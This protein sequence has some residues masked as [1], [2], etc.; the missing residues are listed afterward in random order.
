MKFDLGRLIRR[1]WRRRR[2]TAEEAVKIRPDTPIADPRDDRLGFVVFAEA[3]ADIVDSERTSTP[4]TIALSAP[5]GAGKTSVARMVETL[6][7]RRVAAREDERPRLTCWFNAWEH[8]DA[9]HLGAALAARVAHTAGHNRAIWRRLL[10]PLPAAMLGPRERWRRRLCVVLIAAAGAGVLVLLHR[11]R[12]LAEQT[13]HLDKAF[14][15]GLGWLGVLWIAALLWP[16]LFAAG[17]DAARFLDDPRS[18]AAKGLMSQVG[19]QLGDLIRRG[20]RG[21]RM[22]I[23][24][25]D[26]ERCPARRAVE[27]FEVATQLLAHEGVVT[28]L[29]ADMRALSDAAR[30][31]YQ[32]ESGQVDVDL[33]RR[34][35]EKLVQ[36]ELELPPPTRDSML[37]LLEPERRPTDPEPKRP[38][39]EL[40]RRLSELTATELQSWT[41]SLLGVT[42][43]ALVVTTLVTS[44][45]VARSGHGGGIYAVLGTVGAVAAVGSLVATFVRGRRQQQRREVRERL[46][47]TTSNRKRGSHLVDEKK[48]GRLEAY[49][50]QEARSYDVDYST[51]VAA[52]EGV[53]R[54]Y[55]PRTPRSAKRMLNHAR[56][57][58]KISRDREMFRSGSTLEPAHLGKWIVL[59][60]R[61][62][63][64]AEALAQPG[65]AR[66]A[67]D[68]HIPM[69]LPNEKRPA[70][71]ELDRLLGERPEIAAVID[72][73]VYF[74]PAGPR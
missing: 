14:V 58:T 61:W 26:L 19:D 53:I 38:L 28:V 42:S 10:F 54:R 60:E 18:E 27:V 7:K 22:V 43:A 68:R 32:D 13:L 5:W 47:R 9:P 44:L 67:S 69:L 20:Q 63:H 35:L 70:D 66:V 4:L 16:M 52:V 64:L 23:F 6:L 8:S 62:P 65:A 29:L 3:L 37:R 24:V 57:L 21:G 71:D 55:L 15:G 34:Y 17:K 2:L 31:A 73:L 41:V 46:R 48:S 39:W 50:Q 25:D 59:R 1:L 56:L 36:L 12:E 40:R 51:E 74:E 33:G 11:T 72:R 30:A 49:A 45:S